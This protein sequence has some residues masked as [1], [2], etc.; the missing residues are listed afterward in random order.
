MKKNKTASLIIIMSFVLSSLFP[1]YTSALELND[2]TLNA[3][4]YVYFY[5]EC[6]DG[7]KISIDDP[8]AGKETE[9]T[10]FWGHGTG[11]FVGESGSNPQ[12]IITNYHVVKYYDQYVDKKG[13][14]IE[15]IYLRVYFSAN[16][17]V[18]ASVVDKDERM[19]LAILKIKDP[20]DKRIP[21]K[22]YTNQ[23]G[24]VGK[25]VYSIG[26]PGLADEVIDAVSAKSFNDTTVTKGV[27]SRI[28]TEQ[29]TGRTLYQ[30]DAKISSG[31]S[32]G[33]LVTPEGYVIGINTQGVEMLAEYNYAVDINELIPL[34]KT[35]FIPYEVADDGKTD[36]MLIIIIAAAAIVAAA[37]IIII[38]LK[39]ASARTSDKKTKKI[40]VIYSRAAQH[41]NRRI[42][43]GNS[44]LVIG[45]A[46]SGDLVYAD[47][48][49]GVSSIHCSVSFNAA[50]S[51]FIVTDLNSTYGTFMSNGTRLAPNTFV[52]VIDGSSIYLGDAQNAI[53]F[54]IEEI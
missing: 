13:T 48:T 30:H 2:K 38:F 44:A 46:Q 33:P 17:Y 35:N 28:I 23:S 31:N 54:K 7:Y 27:V 45:R 47:G 34:L 21:L 42:V 9:C 32:G 50:R 18:E 14:E 26:Y 16:D 53:Y 1:L 39:K 40:P 19:D 5:G 22:L 36:V 15:T 20:T 12:Y 10:V 3:I 41:G 25:D 51:V 52:E 24:I 43:I 6:N 8:D 4:A 37:G 49:P 11:F 29:S